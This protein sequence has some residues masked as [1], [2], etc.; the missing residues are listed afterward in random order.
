MEELDRILDQFTDPLAGSLH[1]AAF[2]AIDNLG[3]VIYKRAA[4][5]ADFDTPSAKPL[6][7]D[8]LYWIAS[9]TKMVTAV[10]VM[11]LVERGIISLDDDIREKVP[12]LRDIQI[13]EDMKYDSSLASAQPK[14]VPV[15]GKIVI[16]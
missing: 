4:G 3:N 16:R 5:K 14:L 1:G 7:I 8:S 6:G 9:M 2:I 11:Q 13:L 10:A 15:Q 12:E